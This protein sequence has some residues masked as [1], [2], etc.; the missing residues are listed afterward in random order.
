MTSHH[1]SPASQKDDIVGADKIDVR[2]QHE[3]EKPSGNSLQSRPSNEKDGEY[4]DSAAAV[5][6]RSGKK[7][8]G[9]LSGVACE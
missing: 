5:S 8:F 4:D 7:K 3:H 1:P 6:E 9:Q 2:G